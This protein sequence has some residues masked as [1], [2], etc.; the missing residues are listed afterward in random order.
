[1]RTGEDEMP[2]ARRTRA[3]ADSLKGETARDKSCKDA[4]EVLISRQDIQMFL[5]CS[6][7]VDGPIARADL[8]SGAEVG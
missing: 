2:M 4:A 3:E 6:N 7:T 5:L 1:M 8:G